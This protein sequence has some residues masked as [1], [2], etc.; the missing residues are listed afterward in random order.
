MKRLS[1]RGEQLIKGFEALRLNAYRDQAGIWT[2]GWGH[3]GPE[4][5]A[6]MTCTREQAQAWFDRDN[7]AAE[8]VVN[9]LDRKREHGLTQAQFDALVSFEFNTG[10]LS[11]RRNTIT[12]AVIACR[13]GEVDDEMLRWNKITDPVTKKKVVSAGLKRRRLAEADMFAS[14]SS[15]HGPVTMR[16]LELTFDATT[17]PAAPPTP[18]QAAAS[19]PGVQGSTVATVS[20]VLATTT[21]QIQPLATYSDALRIIFVLLA[22]A[23]V[24]L[25][26]Y[27]ATRQKGAAA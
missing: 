26:I 4:V 12:R 2:I 20:A 21:E 3:T 13:D 11:N 18:A 15:T 1:V 24:G 9:A 10:A 19:S 14:G 5:H 8:S 23:G 16:D 22:L 25:A 6:G 17:T 7:D 27:G